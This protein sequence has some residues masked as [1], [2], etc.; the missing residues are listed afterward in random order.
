MEGDVVLGEGKVTSVLGDTIPYVTVSTSYSE[1]R[2][3]SLFFID[4]ELGR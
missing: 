2:D 1:A 3:F 4:V